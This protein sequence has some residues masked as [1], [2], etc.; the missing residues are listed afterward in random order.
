ML[1][2]IIDFPSSPSAAEDMQL[3]A[4]GLRVFETIT[5]VTTKEGRDVRSA[6]SGLYDQAQRAVDG[7]ASTMPTQSMVSL[8]PAETL[9]GW[10]QSYSTAQASELVSH[11]KTLLRLWLTTVFHI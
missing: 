9:R 8:G 7:A 5:D 6:I 2:N 3:A 4:H 10:E 11:F 1:A